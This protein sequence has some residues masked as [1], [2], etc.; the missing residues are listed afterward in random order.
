MIEIPYFLKLPFHS[1]NRV[2]IFFAFFFDFFFD[3]FLPSGIIVLFDMYDKFSS[4]FIF[5]ALPSD[6]HFS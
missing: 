3:L 5:L 4:F 2:R 1:S 6:V